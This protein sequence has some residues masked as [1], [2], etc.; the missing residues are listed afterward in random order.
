M[1]EASYNQI[2]QQIVKHFDPEKIVL[3]GSLAWGRPH[4]QSDIDLFIVMESPLRRDKRAMAISHLFKNR[5]FPMDIIVYT[6]QELKMS[7]KRGNPFIR[8][9]MDKGRVLYAA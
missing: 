6:S 3:F 9:I 2:V 8:E 4:S 1:T 7:L 5:R